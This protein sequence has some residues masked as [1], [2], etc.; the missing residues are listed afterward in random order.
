[1]KLYSTVITQKSYL[2]KASRSL[3]NISKKGSNR[4]RFPG[5][6]NVLY[7]HDKVWAKMHKRG[8]D[9]HNVNLHTRYYKDTGSL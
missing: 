7:T 8:F 6:E 1:M 9:H 3:E 5:K 4:A 2:A